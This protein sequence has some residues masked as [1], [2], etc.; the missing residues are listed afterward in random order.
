[1]KRGIREGGGLESHVPGKD[2][3][4]TSEP[5]SPRQT[6]TSPEHWNYLGVEQDHADS[7]ATLMWF[8]GVHS[9]SPGY[10]KISMMNVLGIPAES[11]FSGVTE[12]EAIISWAS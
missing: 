3:F 2:V 10:S 8:V 1:M 4:S 6:S 7:P 12:T 9:K 5:I 11:I